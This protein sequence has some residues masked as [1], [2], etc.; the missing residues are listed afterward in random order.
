LMTS[1]MGVRSIRCS[2]MEWVRSDH[3][4]GIIASGPQFGVFCGLFLANLTV[5]A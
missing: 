3:K 1:T 2:S 4:R 5:L